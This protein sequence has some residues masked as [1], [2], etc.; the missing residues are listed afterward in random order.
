M[1]DLERRAGQRILYE[2][3]ALGGQYLSIAESATYLTLNRQETIARENT[4]ASI[5]ETLSTTQNNSD[6]Y[7]YVRTLRTLTQ[8]ELFPTLGQIVSDCY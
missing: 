6:A 5:I 8:D 2:V 4:F 7:R 1:K 3:R